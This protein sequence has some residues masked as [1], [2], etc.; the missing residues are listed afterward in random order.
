M[1]GIE[2]P[3]PP[4]RADPKTFYCDYVPQLWAAFFG[5]MEVPD[6]RLTIGYAVTDADGT[7]EFTLEV[8]GAALT[9]RAEPAEAPLVAFACNHEAWRISVFDIWRR[10]VRFAQPK[11]EEARRKLPDFLH[12]NPPQPRLDAIASLPG[13][14][15]VEFE[16]D[17]GDVAQYDISVAGGNGPRGTLALSDADLWG[18]LRS[19]GRLSQLLRSRARLDGNVGW[20]L[21]LARAL[22][23]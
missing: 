1:A 11:V 15:S 10:Y 21:K 12:R 20:I 9:V 17:A 8:D 2:L 4:R 6:C 18:L 23:P 3:A 19:R 5:G 13:T 7:S 22:E 14:L 16:D